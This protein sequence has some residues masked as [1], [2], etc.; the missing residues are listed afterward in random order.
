[1]KTNL[2]RLVWHAV[3]LVIL[4]ATTLMW[5]LRGLAR[6]DG[7][8]GRPTY[9]AY[10]WPAPEPDASTASAGR[11]EDDPRARPLRQTPRGGPVPRADGY[12][13]G[14][15]GADSILPPI[16]PVRSTD[17]ARQ[18]NVFRNNAIKSCFWPGPKL[19]TGY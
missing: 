13:M 11:A 10:T 6:D 15:L 7:G 9:G 1:M 19:R 18:N 5:W 8:A 12:V 16:P 2:R 3:A 4:L 14:S 17:I